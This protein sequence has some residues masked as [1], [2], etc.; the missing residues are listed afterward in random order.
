MTFPQARLTDSHIC[1]LSLGAPAPITGPCAPTVLVQYLPAARITDLCAGVL[2]PGPHPIVKGSATVL[3][4][5]LPA[6]RMGVDPCA[7]GGAIVLGAM[8][9]LTG[10]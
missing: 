3:I 8:T 1:A 5:C 7:G 2:P 6:A 4:S 9:V 10:G